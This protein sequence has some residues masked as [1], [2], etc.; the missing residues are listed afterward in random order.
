MLRIEDLLP[1]LLTRHGA[2]VIRG[3]STHNNDH[4]KAIAQ[5]F[6][7]S[8]IAHNEMEKV[9][10]ICCM[11]SLTN[12]PPLQVPVVG[13]PHAFRNGHYLDKDFNSYFVKCDYYCADAHRSSLE[14]QLRMNGPS[15]STRNKA[16]F[17]PTGCLKLERMKR[18]CDGQPAKDAIMYCS[19]PLSHTSTFLTDGQEM[20]I[21]L[22]RYFPDK[23][24]IVR[25]YPGD[26]HD[27]RI[28]AVV[29]PFLKNERFLLDDTPSTLTYSPRAAVVLSNNSTVGLLWSYATLRPFVDHDPYREDLRAQAMPQVV[30]CGYRTATLPQLVT[31]VAACLKDGGYFTENIKTVRDTAIVH[32]GQAEAVLVDNIRH[33]LDGRD[34]ADWV[35]L[36]VKAIPALTFA[37][38]ADEARAFAAHELGGKNALY[39]HCLPETYRTWHA[40]HVFLYYYYQIF[41]RQAI[42]LG[43][44]KTDDPF[45]LT[46]FQPAPTPDAS[47]EQPF[48]AWGNPEAFKPYELAFI[49]KNEKSFAG[50]VTSE[51]QSGVRCLAAQEFF[52]RPIPWILFPG[53]PVEYRKI[54]HHYLYTLLRWRRTQ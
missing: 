24:L 44:R 54:F 30:D 21:L 3:Y 22:L 25:P 14:R 33:I 31:A 39:V 45:A 7:Y 10:L 27:P 35:H 28:Q 12:N 18:I 32:V 53:Q 49:D 8:H 13:F 23:R 16:V 6:G 1:D 11:E 47:W 36:P 52:S 26:A 43:E 34:K 48:A 46:P 40:L 15:M 4:D 51:S 20:I 2:T 9:D 19:T 50:F 38:P 5:Q 37:S 41:S 42:V 29:A 17:M